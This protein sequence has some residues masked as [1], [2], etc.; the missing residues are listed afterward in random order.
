MCNPPPITYCIMLYFQSGPRQYYRETVN[1][2]NLS[3]RK[4]RIT[5]HEGRQ[6]VDK[7]R[8]LPNIKKTRKT[9]SERHEANGIKKSIYRDK[10]MAIISESSR[11]SERS[12]NQC[13]CLWALGKKPSSGIQNELIMVGAVSLKGAHS[14]VVVVLNKKTKLELVISFPGLSALLA[15]NKSQ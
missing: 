3:R 11:N 13:P 12:S 1:D 6:C 9:S 14:H 4:T 8:C 15:M 2:I 10:K 7:K 5:Q